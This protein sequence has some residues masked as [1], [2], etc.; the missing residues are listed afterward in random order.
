MMFKL[1]K[2]NEIKALIVPSPSEAEWEYAVQVLLRYSLVMTSQNSEIMPII[3]TQGKTHP[4]GQKQ[5]NPWGL[6]DMHGNVWEWVQDR[7]Q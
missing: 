7:A 5:P 6:Y 2:L 3:R 4:V 1:S